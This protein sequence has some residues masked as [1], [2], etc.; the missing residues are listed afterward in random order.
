MRAIS[1]EYVGSLSDAE[2]ADIAAEN[3]A[4]SSTRTETG[5]K[6]ERMDEALNLA[7]ALSI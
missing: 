1:P 5:Y 7:E 6:L 3:Y 4:T 2:L